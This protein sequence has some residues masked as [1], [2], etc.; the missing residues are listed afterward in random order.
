MDIVLTVL[1][2]IAVGA[3]SGISCAMCLHSF[4]NI[5]TTHLYDAQRSMIDRHYAYQ[6]GMVKMYA[7][8]LKEVTAA[9][10]N[11]RARRRRRGKHS[12][13]AGA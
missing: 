2:V 7:R 13:R 5:E 4:F 3:V 6:K 11:T 12:A 1:A 8:S 10:G 9:C